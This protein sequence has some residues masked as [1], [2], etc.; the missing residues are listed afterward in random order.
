MDSELGK[1]LNELLRQNEALKRAESLYLTLEANRKPMLARL[2]LGAI[3]R[4]HAEREAIAYAGDEWAKF[5]SGHV[6]A[7]ADYQFA[8]RRYEIFD[9]AYLAEHATFNRDAKTISRLGSVT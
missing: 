9:K 7:E 2:T 8:R 1:R 3:G 4:S 5:M 6:Q